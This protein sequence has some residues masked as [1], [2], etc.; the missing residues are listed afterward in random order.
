M[1]VPGV[2][3]PR[4]CHASRRAP[5]QAT[6]S[7]SAQRAVVAAE[8]TSSAAQHRQLASNASSNAIVRWPAGASR[9]EPAHCDPTK[10]GADTPSWPAQRSHTELRR[11]KP[12]GSVRP[13]QGGHR[14]AHFGATLIVRSSTATNNPNRQPRITASAPDRTTSMS[15]PVSRSSFPEPACTRPGPAPQ[16]PRSPPSPDLST[17]AKIA[18]RTCI[19][20]A[21]PTLRASALRRDIAFDP[22]R[23]ALSNDVPDLVNRFAVA[24]RQELRNGF[25][26]LLQTCPFR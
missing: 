21:E 3:L 5:V 18:S 17:P 15:P 11:Q 14:P 25:H 23:T 1:V 12:N 22:N 13:L 10:A 24:S 2:H 7:T 9:D 8:R 6:R 20:N 16:T 4:S 26:E 19:Q